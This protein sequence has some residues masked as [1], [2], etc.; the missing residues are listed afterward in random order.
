MTEVLEDDIRLTERK[1]STSFSET[2]STIERMKRYAE[3]I[4]KR[5]AKKVAKKLAKK[6]KKKAFGKKNILLFLVYLAS[7]ISNV[8]ILLI[9]WKNDCN[10]GLWT[11]FL[12]YTIAMIPFTIVIM[13][14]WGA[15]SFVVTVLHFFIV[16]SWSIVGIVDL[17]EE[18][19]CN[20]SQS[21]SF[22]LHIWCL[23]QLIAHLLFLLVWAVFEAV[24][25]GILIGTNQLKNPKKRYAI[26]PELLNDPTLSKFYDPDDEDDQPNE[27]NDE[28][29]FMDYFPI[30]D[31]AAHMESP[32]ATLVRPS[33]NNPDTTDTFGLMDDIG[34]IDPIFDDI[35]KKNH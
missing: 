3:R 23:V 32:R 18:S 7:I 17:A 16:T 12:I 6:V 10:S 33:S 8:I 20:V 25:I 27:D 31:L 14:T 19:A 26:P 1:V 35:S 9:Y 28:P 2:N 24:R 5:N 34:E 22:F 4:R 11:W 30:D 13:W 15:V 21:N 29:P